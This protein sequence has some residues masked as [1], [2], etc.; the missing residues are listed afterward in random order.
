M[1]DEGLNWSLGETARRNKSSI[2]R[3][4]QLSDS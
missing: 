3:R 2:D 4:E 1:G